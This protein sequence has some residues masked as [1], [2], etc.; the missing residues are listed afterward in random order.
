MI[1]IGQGLLG[2]IQFPDGTFPSYDRPYLVVSVTATHVGLL[3]VSSTAGKEHKLLFPENRRLVK[4]DPP[5]L[6]DSFVKLDSLVY[7]PISDVDRFRLLHSGDCLEEE[8]LLS[9]LQLLSNR[10]QNAD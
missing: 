2:R 10:E 3:N 8:E 4:H 6:K 5:F 7:I 1:R 9:I